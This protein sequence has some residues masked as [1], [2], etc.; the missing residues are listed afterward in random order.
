[1]TISSWQILACQID[2]IVLDCIHLKWRI[3]III[4]ARS[5][6][7]PGSTCHL[8]VEAVPEESPEYQ[9]FQHVRAETSQVF[10]VVTTKMMWRGLNKQWLEKLYNV[11]YEW[12]D[13][14]EVID[15]RITQVSIESQKERANCW[16]PKWWGL[17]Q[18]LGGKLH[19]KPTH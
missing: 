4:R 17:G 15:V 6:D 1:M 12:G 3:I 2:V 19:A 5:F 7:V 9:H 14:G 10:R 8:Q 13:G 11:K 18:L 16:S